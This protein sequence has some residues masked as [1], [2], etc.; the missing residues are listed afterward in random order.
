GN[1]VAGV[2]TFLAV[3]MFWP[4]TRKRIV[5][6]VGRYFSAVHTKLDAQHAEHLALAEKHH[7]EAVALAKKHHEIHMA[8]VAPRAPTARKP[9]SPSK[10]Q[11]AR[12]RK[13]V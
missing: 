10:K 7:R 6:F 8:A 2:V 11:P 1:I 3:G 13:A 4:P 5:A 9:A 12:P